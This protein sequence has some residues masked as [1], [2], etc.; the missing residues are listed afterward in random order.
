M[1]TIA[2]PRWLRPRRSLLL[3]LA[4]AGLAALLPWRAADLLQQW[5]SLSPI[6]I[7]AAQAPAPTPQ[8]A[9][10]DPPPPA[11]TDSRQT[12]DGKLLLEVARRKAE[13]DHREQEL[14]TRSAQIAAAEM[15]ARRQIGEL[16]RLRQQVETL[17]ASQFSAAEADLNLC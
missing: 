1:K 11:V 15:L 4:T 3:P 10:A 8:Q 16:Q 14:Q 6:G 7:A 13:L 5:H 12:E 9:A 2:I 17:A